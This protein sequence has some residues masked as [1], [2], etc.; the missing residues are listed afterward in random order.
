MASETLRSRTPAILVRPL[1][2]RRSSSL[3][4]TLAASRAE[5]M[6]SARD[7]ARV[8]LRDDDLLQESGRTSIAGV[9]ERRVSEAMFLPNPTARHARSRL[10]C[11]IRCGLLIKV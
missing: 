4:R 8:R 7:A 5:G 1:S 11:Y 6:F 2:C 10:A 3:S 9:L